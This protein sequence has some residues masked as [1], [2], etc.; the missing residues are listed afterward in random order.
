MVAEMVGPNNNDAVVGYIIY[1]LHKL[2]LECVKLVADHDNH[3]V[4]SSLLRKITSKLS[5]HRPWVALNVDERSL[6]LQL[7]LKSKGWSCVR[8]IRRGE[9]DESD[10]Y[11]FV[12]NIPAASPVEG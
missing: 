12:Y 11:R 3:A 5:S 7:L 8:V 4:L 6:D 9:D 10:S 2:K 1:E